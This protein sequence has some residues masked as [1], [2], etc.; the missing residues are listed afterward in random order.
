MGPRGEDDVE[1]WGTKVPVAA[2][3]KSGLA[4]ASTSAMYHAAPGIVN[5]GPGTE[6][7]CASG[8]C[9]GSGGCGSETVGMCTAGCV[10][11]SFR[12]TM[13]KQE[14]TIGRADGLEP[15]VALVALLV[16]TEVLTI[17]P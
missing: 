8:T 2:P 13:L 1:Y 16:E 15:L 3:Y 9:G 7:S 17:V 10:G 14:L 6:G 5:A 4:A 11:V 12:V